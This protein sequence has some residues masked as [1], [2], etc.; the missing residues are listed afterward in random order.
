MKRFWEWLKRRLGWVD[1]PRCGLLVRL[2]WVKIPIYHPEEPPIFYR[3]RCPCG[4]WTS[5]IGETSIATNAARD[6]GYGSA[7]EIIEKRMK[8]EEDRHAEDRGDAES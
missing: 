6:L 2:R 4:L 3:Y 5:A 7:G 1:C 8:R